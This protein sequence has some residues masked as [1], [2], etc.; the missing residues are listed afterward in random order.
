[1][2]LDR[3]GVAAD[4]VGWLL[5]GQGRLQY[6][7]PHRQLGVPS[8]LAHH[9]IQQRP[10]V[11]YCI[12]ELPQPLHPCL[13]LLPMPLQA[14]MCFCQVPRVSIQ[15]CSLMTAGADELVLHWLLNHLIQH[16]GQSFLVLHGIHQV[17]QPLNPLLGLLLC[18]YIH[19]C[20]RWFPCCFVGQWAHP[21]AM[22]FGSTA[23]VLAECKL[24]YYRISE[25]LGCLVVQRGQ[26]NRLTRAVKTWNGWQ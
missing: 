2:M 14:N 6:F 12:D 26:I 9:L 22:R 3:E 4:G 15:E 16:L 24:K 23:K 20:W 19:D 10:L 1:M 11:L 25:C 21:G 5:A 8:R 13:G 7:Q 17:P 18:P